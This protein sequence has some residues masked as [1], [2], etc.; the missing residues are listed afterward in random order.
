MASRQEFAEGA[1]L[2]WAALTIAWGLVVYVLLVQKNILLQLAART[3]TY[4]ICHDYCKT[5][6]N[7]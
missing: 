6:D 1:L 7:R 4:M 2:E 3:S 5:A